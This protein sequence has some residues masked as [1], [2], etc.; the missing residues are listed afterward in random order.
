[1]IL[2]VSGNVIIVGEKIA[3]IT[4]LWWIEH[5]FYGIITFLVFY[6]VFYSI[7]RIHRAPP[8]PALSLSGNMDALRLEKFGK[9]LCSHCD[10]FLMGIKV[11]VARPEFRL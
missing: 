6:Y 4:H 9:S 10:Y 5:V 8:F 3:K 1:M 2:M 11:I 7:V